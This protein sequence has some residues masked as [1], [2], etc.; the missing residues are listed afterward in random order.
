M[1]ATHQPDP[2]TSTTP[3]A[4]PHPAAFVTLTAPALF[5]EPGSTVAAWSLP[6]PA[7]VGGP[8][9]VGAILARLR[10]GLE[11][12]RKP[13]PGQLVTVVLSGHP[14]AV[15]DLARDLAAITRVVSMRHTPMPGA[16]H[17][18]PDSIRLVVLCYRPE[19]IV[20]SGGAA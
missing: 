10:K 14:A 7:P 12:M 11:A 17:S 15:T 8:E 19:T 4:E 6:S 20:A 9:R 13:R 3:T 16:V 1:N 2:T 18:A 5:P